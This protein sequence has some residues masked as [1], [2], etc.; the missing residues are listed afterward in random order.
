MPARK[1]TGHVVSSQA[2]K[3]ILV[4]VVERRRHPLY[5]KQYK[6]TRKYQAHDQDNE[7]GLGDRVRIVESRPLSKSKNWR[8]LK[9][10]E[11]AKEQL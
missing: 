5:D 11:K 3:T 4:E 2:A 1:A 6:V 8:L 7:A 9:V 10:I